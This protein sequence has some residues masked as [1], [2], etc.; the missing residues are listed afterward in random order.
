MFCDGK[1]F[2][3]GATVLI[4][5]AMAFCAA[6]QE[7]SQPERWTYGSPVELAPD[8]TAPLGVES[9]N[10]LADS[11]HLDRALF[12]GS[13]GL[14]AAQQRG[15]WRRQAD[16]SIEQVRYRQSDLATFLPQGSIERARFEAEQR[17]ITYIRAWPLIAGEG[18]AFQFEI[19]PH[20]G[21][22]VNAQGG[23]AEAGATVRVGQLEVADGDAA[24]DEDEGRWYLFA[25]GTGTAVGMNWARGMDGWDRRLSHDT[26]S[27]IGD[28]QVGA[29]WRRGDTQTSFGYVH[30]EVTADGV[31]GGTGIDRD[32]TEGFGA[33]Q[34]SLR[35]TW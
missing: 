5:T 7:A 33:L 14:V 4:G 19:T 8:H 17:E 28:A 27:F 23:T 30:R 9:L 2:V 20:A 34:F 12:S 6:A 18:R 13:Q 11:Q 25:A 10:R 21:V 29:A 35:P 31:H 22:G 1:Q 24:Y 26:G 32:A 16:G 15:V 3:A